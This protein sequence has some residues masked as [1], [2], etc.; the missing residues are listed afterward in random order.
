MDG[1][2]VRGLNGNSIFLPYYGYIFDGRI[3]L[4]DSGDRYV[5]SYA[6]YWSKTASS[7]S[8]ETG[9]TYIP[10]SVTFYEYEISSGMILRESGCLV[11]PVYHP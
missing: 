11:R 10:Y 4:K 7:S 6:A 3:F 5:Y 1:Y 8:T 2:E 9:T